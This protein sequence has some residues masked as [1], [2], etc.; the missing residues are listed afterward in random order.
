MHA[1]L[2]SACGFPQLP[3][4]AILPRTDQKE[5]LCNS[6]C[7]MLRLS[8]LSKGPQAAP[9]S[10]MEKLIFRPL[11]LAKPDTGRQVLLSFV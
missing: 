8:E 1:V 9:T 5:A 4:S 11:H 10:T 6:G 3:L 2:S 7:A